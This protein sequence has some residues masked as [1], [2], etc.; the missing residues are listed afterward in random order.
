MVAE[1]PE[2]LD[3]LSPR[4]RRILEARWL[5]EKDA[6]T[7]R[8]LAEELGVS[9]ERVRQLEADAFRKVKHAYEQLKSRE[10]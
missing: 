2:I 3:C 7:L 5:S 10:G 8:Q 6:L 1:V 9:S 4:R